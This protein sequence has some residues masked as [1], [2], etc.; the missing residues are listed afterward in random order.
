MAGRAAGAG[1]LALTTIFGASLMG[2]APTNLDELKLPVVKVDD[3]LLAEWLSESVESFSDEPLKGECSWF[4]FSAANTGHFCDVFTISRTQS[5]TISVASARALKCMA[6]GKV[7]CVLSTEIGL[8]V[9]AAFLGRADDPDGVKTLIA[10][11][12]VPFVA[13]DAPPK[14]QHVRVNI[15]TDTFGSRTLVFNNSVRAEYL[16]ADKKVRSEVFTGND[17]FCVSLLRVAFE[18]SCWQALDGQ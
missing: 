13:G 17:A 18:E 14:P 6:S 16:T 8:G 10:P 12:R 15:P 11:R 2:D 7:E 5:A 3:A 4:N 9:P 1:G